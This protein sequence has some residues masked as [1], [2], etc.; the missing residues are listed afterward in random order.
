MLEKKRALI[1]PI[2][3]ATEA[4]SDT[5]SY[6]ASYLQPDYSG[7]VKLVS[8][9]HVFAILQDTETGI[10]IAGDAISKLSIHG[11]IKIFP[12]HGSFYTHS[13]L[14]DWRRWARVYNEEP[15]FHHNPFSTSNKQ[16]I[17]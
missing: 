17:R 11:V 3:I 13:S 10:Q 14:E 4:M 15:R 6:I 12:Y 9:G 5:R 1:E 7:P 8:N 16:E 2:I